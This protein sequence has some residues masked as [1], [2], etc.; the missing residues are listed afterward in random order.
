MSASK[1]RSS[2]NSIGLAVAKVPAA[3]HC[4]IAKRFTRSLAR[5]LRLLETPTPIGAF[6]M[7]ASYRLRKQRKH[8]FRNQPPDPATGPPADGPGLVM[9]HPRNGHVAIEQ[10]NLSKQSQGCNESYA[11]SLFGRLLS[12]RAWPDLKKPRR[13]ATLGGAGSEAS[14]SSVGRF[15]C[16]EQSRSCHKAAKCRFVSRLTA[17]RQNSA[18]GPLNA[19]HSAW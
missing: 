10:K 1:E 18:H 5:P 14:R 16:N 19:A 12:H 13:R 2:L 11:R 15:A 17:P 7:S 3:Q 8:F 4:F 9:T 6:S